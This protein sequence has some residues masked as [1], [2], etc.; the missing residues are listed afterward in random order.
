MN[1][2]TYVVRLHVI[3]V[4]VARLHVIADLSVLSSPQILTLSAKKN[5]KIPPN[6]HQNQAEKAVFFIRRMKFHFSFS[7]I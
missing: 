5:R 6:F 1:F 4:A 3:H 7:K 2:A